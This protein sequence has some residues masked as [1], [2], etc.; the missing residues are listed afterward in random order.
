MYIYFEQLDMQFVILIGLLLCGVVYA[1]S[2]AVGFPCNLKFNSSLLVSFGSSWFWL[3][4]WITVK[5]QNL[6]Y[7]Y[8][9]GCALP[10]SWISL[11]ASFEG[12]Y[13]MFLIFLFNYDVFVTREL[14]HIGIPLNGFTVCYG[15]NTLI[16]SLRE[17][18]KQRKTLNLW[19]NVEF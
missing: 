8:F 18:S 7:F 12:G 16:E 6:C 15:Y 1:I 5:S 13:S 19:V 3:N 11:I 17:T 2:A 9:C 4:K 10:S 14:W